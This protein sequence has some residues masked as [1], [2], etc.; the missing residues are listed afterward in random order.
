VLI[1]V[2]VLDNQR[3][4]HKNGVSI[5]MDVLF[6]TAAAMA[7]DICE[8]VLSLS[9]SSYAYAY[10]HALSFSLYNTQT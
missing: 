6:V 10:D 7:M 4:R 9:S 1:S 2:S 3:Q 8:S 5:L